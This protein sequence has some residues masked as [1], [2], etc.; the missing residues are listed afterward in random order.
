[1]AQPDV[2]YWLPWGT[3]GVSFSRKEPCCRS[4][5]L[6]WWNVR[7]I[8]K[9]C[10]ILLAWPWWRPWQSSQQRF[11]LHSDVSLSCNVFIFFIS[12]PNNFVRDNP[13]FTV[14]LTVW[15]LNKTIFVQSVVRWQVIDQTDVRS[16]ECLDWTHTTIVSVVHVTYFISSTVT[17]QTTGPKADKRRLWDNSES[18][19][20]W[21]MNCDNTVNQRFFNCSCY[22]TDIDN[23]LWYQ[24]IC[25]EQTYT[26]T[27]DITFHTRK[28]QT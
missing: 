18:R 9:Q 4:S 21:S 10:W 17:S 16:F 23:L 20:C 7:V 3:V 24:D 2:A 8:N 19:L 6:F 14:N 26:F 25:P 15:C 5:Y 22:R 1:M 28:S 12:C 13:C 27:P 11:H